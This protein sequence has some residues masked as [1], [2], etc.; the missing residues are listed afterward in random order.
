M[1]SCFSAN[2][3]PS[4]MNNTAISSDGMATG[5]INDIDNAAL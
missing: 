4:K 3:N 1:Q 2:E 5:Q